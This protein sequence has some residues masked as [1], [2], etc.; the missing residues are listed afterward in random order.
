[1][2][3]LGALLGLTLAV[4][5]CAPARSGVTVSSTRVPEPGGSP[6]ATSGAHP[7]SD[8]PSTPNPGTDGASPHGK[9]TTTEA[10]V[11]PG[12]GKR[13]TMPLTVTLNRT[14]AEHGDEMVSEAVTTAGAQLTFAAGYSSSNDL[15]PD[16][17]YVPKEANATGSHTWRWVIRP[18]IRPGDAILSVVASKEGKGASYNIPFRIAASC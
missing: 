8:A 12:P 15:P 7:G 17:E 1:M 11:A 18:D 3:L 13:N 4:S 10:R 2:R 14:C 9:A 6:P 5:A 16:F